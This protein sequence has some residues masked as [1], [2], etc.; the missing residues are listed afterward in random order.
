MWVFLFG[1]RRGRDSEAS[2]VIPIWASEIFTPALVM[3]IRGKTEHLPEMNIVR[4]LDIAV[5]FGIARFKDGQG[6][7][8]MVTFNGNRHW[9]FPHD[10]T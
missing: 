6:S 4:A 5:C 3:L 1:G 9:V 7:C 8:E 2:T 10:P